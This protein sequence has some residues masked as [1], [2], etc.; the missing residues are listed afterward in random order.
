MAQQH[1]DRLS[2][3]DAGFLHM[4]DGN[5]AHMH[6]GA[7]AVLEGPPPDYD[8][9]CAHIASRLQLVPRYR[10]R[11]MPAPLQTGRPLW[12]EDPD[13]NLTYHVRLTA[14]PSPGTDEQLR[15]LA[16]RIVSQ[17]LDRTKPLWEIW[18]VEGLEGGR[19][20]VVNKTHHALV[21]GVGGVDIL[22]ALFDLTPEPRAVDPDTWSAE[23]AP[24]AVDLL[25]K[26]VRDAAGRVVGLSTAAIGAVTDPRRTL[27]R[28]ARTAQGVVEVAERFVNPAPRTPLNAPPGP[29]RRFASVSTSLADYKA[30]KNR[31]GGTVNDVVLTVVAG[32]LARFLEQRG[33]DTSGMELRACVPVSVRTDDQRGG[34]GNRITIMVA[35]LP[36]G[37][38]DPVA[39]LGKVR[40]AMDGLKRSKQAI[41]A[42]AMTEMENFM[43]PTVLAR[44]ARLGFSSRLY[45][46]L[47]TNVPG[48]QFPVY[49]LGRQMLALYPIAFL[50]PEHLLAVG[51]VSYHGQVNIGLIADYDGVPDL[52]VLAKEVGAALDELVAAG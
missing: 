19:F 47:V 40:A 38:R 44:A 43:P 5:D 49:L 7:L 33:L 23:P 12:V 41:G 15:R 10:Q 30:V 1:L 9:F 26:G 35:P 46:L 2:S 11:V 27:A 17:R 16:G 24:G 28:A 21:D 20:A 37:E 32:A 52:D 6:I 8:E 50:A 14:L 29:H 48:P 42:A 18:L 25:A 31:L 22:T 3:V 39:R 36:V 51:I 34:A 4:E 13:F 45:N